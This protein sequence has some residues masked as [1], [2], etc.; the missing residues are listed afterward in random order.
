[1]TEPTAEEK[2]LLAQGV[3]PA[4]LSDGQ[5]GGGNKTPAD[6]GVTK[7]VPEPTA[8][9]KAAAQKVIDD[10]AA[11]DKLVADE[12]AAKKAGTDQVGKTEWAKS[13]DPV[14]NSVIEMLT[15]SGVSPMEGSAIFDK[16]VASG[17]LEDI[18]WDA[19]QKKVKPGQFTLIKAGVEKYYDDQYKPVRETVAKGHE[20]VGG[21]ENW[22]KVRD[23]AQK[24]EKAG[25]LPQ[26]EEI[27][28]AIGQN[29]WIAQKA[30][31][32]L[33]SLYEK[34]PSNKGLGV[35]KITEGNVN[36]VIAAGDAL[37][38]AD[39]RTELNKL[40]DGFREPDPKKLAALQA[41]RKAG[42]AANL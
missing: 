7:P 2:A 20:I 32:E 33:K 29:G 30:I 14:Y 27:R 26:I 41:R 34:D 21:E 9:E 15:D 28:R 6:T 16:A 5:M 38:A 42:M 36:Q 10:K 4:S 31:E 23:W 39:Y 3:T 40:R 35:N 37:N 17:N 22:I 13:E 25:K 18:D 24:A 19:L 12:A 8:E 11:A 1:M